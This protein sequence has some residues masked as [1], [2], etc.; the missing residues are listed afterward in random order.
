MN[1]D[2]KKEINEKAKKHMKN[3]RENMESDEK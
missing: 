2:E 3:K 1:E